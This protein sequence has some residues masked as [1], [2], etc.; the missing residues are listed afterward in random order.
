[1]NVGSHV[2]IRGS[3]VVCVDAM[4]EADACSYW[5]HYLSSIGC[6]VPR[7]LATDMAIPVR[8]RSK[9][10]LHVRLTLQP[11]WS[12]ISKY[13]SCSNDAANVRLAVLKLDT[14][15]NVILKTASKVR[16]WRHFQH[17]EKAVRT[18]RC[19]GSPLYTSILGLSVLASLS[20][21]TSG[22]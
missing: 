10:V 13:S 17:A 19:V 3:T 18:Q 11:I 12:I 22:R 8:L 21:T 6:W 7:K 14:T 1:M 16:S 20:A 5:I 2:R 4:N 15:D 9:Q